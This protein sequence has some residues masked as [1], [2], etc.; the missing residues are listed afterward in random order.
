MRAHELL[1]HVELAESDDRAGERSY[2][3]LFTTYGENISTLTVT[4]GNII[5]L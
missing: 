3:V 4:S 1:Y 2:H 5:L